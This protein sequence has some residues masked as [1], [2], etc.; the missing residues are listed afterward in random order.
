VLDLNDNAGAPGAA[1]PAGG[2]RGGK[3][4]ISTV[5]LNWYP[6]R[7]VRFLLDYQWAD[8]DRLNGA[9]ADI[10]ADF[11]ALSLRSQVAF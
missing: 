3:Q 10:G 8:I 7:T 2:V 9:G 5:G 1:T 11:Q 4:T 6:N